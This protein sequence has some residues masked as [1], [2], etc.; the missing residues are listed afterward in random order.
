M[1]TLCF[2]TP[3]VSWKEERVITKL[4]ALITCLA[5]DSLYIIPMCI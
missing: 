1:I 2:A 3:I 5:L 4:T